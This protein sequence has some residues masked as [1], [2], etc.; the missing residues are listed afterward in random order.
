MGNLCISLY[1][2]AEL[3]SFYPP[4]ESIPFLFLSLENRQGELRKVA[5]CTWSLLNVVNN[6]KGGASGRWQMLG[7]RSRNGSG[8]IFL[9]EKKHVQKENGNAD[10]QGPMHCPISSWHRCTKNQCSRSGMFIPDPGS[11]FLP[12]PDPGSRIPDP[13]TATKERGEKKFFCHTFICSHKFHKIENYFSFEVMKKKIWANFQRIIEL[14]TQKLVTKL[15]L[16]GPGSGK[17]LFR[18]PD[19]EPGVT[20]ALDPGFATL[21]KTNLNFA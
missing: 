1:V 17:N 6:E 18:L 11:W 20:K 9:R 21:Q 3:A 2:I 13:K 12:I 19:P 15:S 14:F 7:N 10:R 5:F 16:W 4:K 8:N